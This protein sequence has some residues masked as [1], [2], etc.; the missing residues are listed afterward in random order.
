MMTWNCYATKTFHDHETLPY[1]QKMKLPLLSK[2]PRLSLLKRRLQSKN[3]ETVCTLSG[4][5]CTIPCQKKEHTF[6]SVLNRFDI[7][8]AMKLWIY[9]FLIWKSLSVHYSRF[10]D[11]PV[12]A[13]KSNYVVRNPSIVVRSRGGCDGRRST[14]QTSIRIWIASTVRTSSITYFLF[15]PEHTA[16]CCTSKT[17]FAAVF[18]SWSYP[19][20]TQVCTGK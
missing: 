2:R 6:S 15:S 11:M 20:D 10:L 1:L 8:M 16:G 14:S 13:L 19:S 9:E 7:L 17:P 5:F 12:K 3:H 18:F 4:Y